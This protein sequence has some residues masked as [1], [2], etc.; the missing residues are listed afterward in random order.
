[1]RFREFI[2][3]VAPL[4]NPASAPGKTATKNKPLE[5]DM[6]KIGPPFPAED[7]EAVKN[8]QKGLENLGY[9][10]GRTGIDGKYGPLTAAAVENFKK[11]YKLQGG[12]DT[13]DADALDTLK[14]I[15]TGVIPKVANPTPVTPPSSKI[16]NTST[17]IPVPGSN[18]AKAIKRVVDAGPGYTDIQTV[19]GEL[20]RRKGARNWRNNNPGNLEFGPFAKSRGAVGTDGRFAVFPTLGAG[21]KAKEDL[22]FGKNYVN[23][24]IYDAIS[25]YAPESDNNDVKAYVNHIV[26]STNASPNTILRDLTAEQRKEMLDAINRFEGFKPGTVVALGSTGSS[27]TA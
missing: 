6:L 22:V 12:N 14:K 21:L 10:V 26:Q 11:D 16:A 13:F 18:D 8:M 19:D 3:A 2:E 17:P 25:K 9:S 4:G 1:M 5:K 20:L 27:S 24:S 15:Q 7:S 23:L